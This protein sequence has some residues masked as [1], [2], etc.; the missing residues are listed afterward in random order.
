MESFR[1]WLDKPFNPRRA[2]AG[3]RR[4]MPGAGSGSRRRRAHGVTIRYEGSFGRSVI[5]VMIVLVL[6]AVMSNVV[7]ERPGQ[8]LDANQVV[9]VDAPR[10]G[11]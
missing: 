1:S 6:F 7:G 3:P 11:R 2:E 5:K 8:D 4:S 10:S 9:T